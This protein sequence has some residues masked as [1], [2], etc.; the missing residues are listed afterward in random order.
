MNS[1]EN[2]KVYLREQRRY[3]TMDSLDLYE[4]MRAEIR[5]D[6]WDEFMRDLFRIIQTTPN[7]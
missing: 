3:H 5:V 4:N 2:D 7:K 1:L 6:A